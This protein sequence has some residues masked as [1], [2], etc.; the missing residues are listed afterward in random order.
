[1]KRMSSQGT[2]KRRAA[3]TIS[4]LRQRG[5]YIECPLG[6]SGE[7]IQL[8]DCGLFYGDDFTEAAVEVYSARV[9]EHSERLK[10]LKAR[11]KHI[12]DSSE[13]GAQAVNSGLIWE[14]LAPCM[15]SFCFDG[16][17]C[18]SLLDPVDYIVFEGLRKDNVTR[19]MFLEI[20]TGKARLK[21]NQQLLQLL[22]KSK[23]VSMKVYAASGSKNG[24]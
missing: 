12:P 8:K 7:P 22:V 6:C 23:S 20:K 4:M 15:D 24:E 18:R 3:E 11:M 1:M 13:S 5:V 14:R 9:D 19:V 16:Y 17:D 2:E 21:P 10:S